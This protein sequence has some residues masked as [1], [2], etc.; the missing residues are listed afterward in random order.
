M[1]CGGNTEKKAGVAQEKSEKKPN[2]HT[3][4]KHKLFIPWAGSEEKTWG[5]TFKEK[6]AAKG[7]STRGNPLKNRGKTS[8]VE[9][10][11][12][13][14]PDKCG[15]SLC[16]SIPNKGFERKGKNTQERQNSLSHSGV[17]S[18]AKPE[19][20]TNR[21]ERGVRRLET[22]T[23]AGAAMLKIDKRGA[24]KKWGLTAMDNS[25]EGGPSQREGKL[26]FWKA[27]D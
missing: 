12:S 5:E 6:K 9:P 23:P 2:Y 16:P 7:F 11:W 8:K 25:K 3:Q 26:L 20:S 17:S 14:E 21:G 27:I 22:P 1:E 18:S 13:T 15:R 10:L 24:D 4:K 19:K